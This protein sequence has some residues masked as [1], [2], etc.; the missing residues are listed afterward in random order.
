MKFFI[1]YDFP[2]PCNCYHPRA[3]IAVYSVYHQFCLNQHFIPFTLNWNVSTAIIIICLCLL[4]N[5]YLPFI[6]LLPFW[7]TPK[8]SPYNVSSVATYIISIV[9]D[10]EFFIFLHI[11]FL[12]TVAISITPHIIFHLL[13]CN[14]SLK[15]Y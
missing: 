13:Y 3:T 7:R 2:Q 5:P 10:D 6:I 12:S 8:I 14:R 11:L 15:F 1:N 9:S 4:I